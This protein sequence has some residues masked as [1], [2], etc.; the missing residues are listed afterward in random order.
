MRASTLSFLLFLLAGAIAVP[1]NAADRELLNRL[2]GSYNGRLNCDLFAREVGNE[3]PEEP[4]AQLSFTGPLRLPPKAGRAVR[5]NLLLGPTEYRFI[6]RVERLRCR[7]RKAIYIGTMILSPSGEGSLDLGTFVGRMRATANPK[8]RRREKLSFPAFL[9][10]V[11][12]SQSPN[13]IYELIGVFN[14]VK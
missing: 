1:S 10:S 2:K 8:G 6:A 4:N 13:I 12:E 5:G 14:A 7:K 3:R 9:T 11:D